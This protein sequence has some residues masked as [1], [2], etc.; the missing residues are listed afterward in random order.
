MDHNKKADPHIKALKPMFVPTPS[1][2]TASKDDEIMAASAVKPQPPPGE[3]GNP[4]KKR[5]TNEDSYFS[6]VALSGGD[7][8]TRNESLFGRCSEEREKD[9]PVCVCV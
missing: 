9:R 5:E 7:D 6:A 8:L 3:P 1:K 4:R 2:P